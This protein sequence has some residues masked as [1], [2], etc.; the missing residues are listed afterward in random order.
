MRHPHPIYGVTFPNEVRAPPFRSSFEHPKCRS[1][2]PIL[3]SNSRAA[4]PDATPRFDPQMFTLGRAALPETPR[5]PPSNPL[6]A[7]ARGVESKASAVGASLRR[8]DRNVKDALRRI[9]GSR[10][11][12]P[13]GA[14]PPP[15]PAER[16]KKTKP[17]KV[18]KKT[19]RKEDLPKPSKGADETRV[20]EYIRASYAHSP[21]RPAAATPGAPPAPAA[22][23]RMP[24]KPPQPVTEADL[25]DADRGLVALARGALGALRDSVRDRDVDPRVAA[26]AAAG[27]LALVVTVA[28]SPRRDGGGDGDGA[29]RDNDIDSAYGGGSPEVTPRRDEK[30][31]ADGPSPRMGPIP[32]R[33]GDA[34]SASASASI[35]RLFSSDKDA[36]NV[37]PVVASGSGSGSG[38]NSRGDSAGASGSRLGTGADALAAAVRAKTTVI[39]ATRRLK[40]A[41]ELRVNVLD[42]SFE[43]TGRKGQHSVRVEV[44]AAGG[45]AKG[46]TP[47]AAVDRR[48]ETVSFNSRLK[49]AVKA[50]KT[51]HEGRQ[52]RVRLCDESGKT[53]AKAG[54]LLR[55]V[56]RA[57]P[58]TKSFPLYGRDGETAGSARVAFEWARDRREES[59]DAAADVLAKPRE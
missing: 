2:S 4:H 55:A 24:P 22:P 42:A 50:D 52:I 23:A 16:E 11:P 48:G 28:A 54:L 10:M 30:A 17:V 31:K 43:S 33:G 19:I 18:V 9:P 39:K 20:K 27:C 1:T 7:F 40:R 26:A 49:F 25:D 34:S 14:A 8:F 38:S 36:K 37:A 51:G 29:R 13:A 35:R 57:A 41:G 53:I 12:L 45:V 32:E 59:S 58:V 47:A 3:S 21:P 44:D 46:A 6:E 56:L 5:A 15:V